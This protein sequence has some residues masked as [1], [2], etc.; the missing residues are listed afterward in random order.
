MDRITF[1]LLVISQLRD[2]VVLEKAFSRRGHA[3][4]ALQQFAEAVQ[5]FTEVTKRNPRIACYFDNCQNAYRGMGRLTDAVADA[6]RAIE[7]A[8]TYAFVWRVRANVYADI[9]VI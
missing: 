9:G 3:R 7:L 4:M 6:N 2:N 5:D 8:A 1:C